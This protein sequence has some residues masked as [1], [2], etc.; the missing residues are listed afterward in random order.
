MRWDRPAKARLE[1][2]NERFHSRMAATKTERHAGGLPVVEHA[3]ELFQ[4]LAGPEHLLEVVHRLAA[5]R[6][7]QRLVDDDRPAPDRCGEQAEHDELD[8]EMRAPEHRPQRDLG[9]DRAQAL[10]HH[11]SRV[12]RQGS[13][14]PE[15]GADPGSLPGSTAYV[16]AGKAMATGSL[17][18]S[19][20]S[21]PGIRRNKGVAAMDAVPPGRFWEFTSVKGSS[22]LT[23]RYRRRA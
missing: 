8:D 11:I 9:R 12:H 5:A 13:F 18:L 4:R 16:S 20:L 15:A 3:V 22:G 21:R 19:R 2:S 1:P 10:G 17:R 6:E 23:G 7:Q 14:R